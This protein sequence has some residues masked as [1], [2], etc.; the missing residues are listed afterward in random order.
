MY[1]WLG[2]SCQIFRFKVRARHRL[3]EI[4]ALHHTHIHILEHLELLARLY[5]FNSHT[6]TERLGELTDHLNERLCIYISCKIRDE[7]LV[8]LDHIERYLA[9]MIER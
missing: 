9:Y 1:C 7:C 2:R 6:H 8:D 4:E 5:T 3:I